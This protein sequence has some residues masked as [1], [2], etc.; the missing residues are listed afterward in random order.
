MAEFKLWVWFQVHLKLNRV[1]HAY[2]HSIQEVEAEG[3]QIQSHAP[4]RSFRPVWNTCKPVSG[5]QLG[6]WDSWAVKIIFILA[7]N[8]GWIPSSRMVAHNHL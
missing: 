2:S 5:K 3:A 7:E 4:L 1:A 8:P 6:D